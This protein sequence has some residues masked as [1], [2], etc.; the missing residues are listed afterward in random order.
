MLAAIFSGRRPER[1]APEVR[2]RYGLDDNLWK[3]IVQCWGK[4][5]VK[6]PSASAIV[7]KLLVWVG[8]REHSN[9]ALSDWDTTV[10]SRLKSTLSVVPTFTTESLEG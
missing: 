6:R 8:T 5:P 2:R 10:M 4:N 1:P 3:L 9:A 7:K